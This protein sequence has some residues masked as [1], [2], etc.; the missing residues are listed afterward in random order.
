LWVALI[1]G[2]A[3]LAGVLVA[4]QR[5]W[6][7]HPH[8]MI[9]G[10]LLAASVLAVIPAMGTLDMLNYAAYGRM[11]V[12]GH[13]PYVS[14]PLE[15]RRA[16]DPIGLL[17]TRAW[18]DVPSTY[19]PV[20]TVTEWTASWLGG[21]SMAWTVLWL[22]VW[23]VLAFAFTALVLDRL[24]GPDR[25]ARA[26]AHALWTLNPLLL[27]HLVAGGHVEAL[28]VGLAVAGLWVVR[29][30]TRTG[31]PWWHL[32][33]AGALLGAAAGVKIPFAIFGLGVACAVRHSARA[34]AAVVLGALSVL[35]TG[36][37]L[38]GP[39]AISAL[40]RRSENPS[41]IDPWRL[42]M[43]MTDWT[44][45]P[46]MLSWGSLGLSAIVAV[47]LLQSLPLWPAEQ[48]AVRIA[49]ATGVAWMIVTPVYFP[50]YE[51]MLVPLLAL[52]PASRL[53]EFTMWRMTIASLASLP[54]VALGFHSDG[55]R[56][57]IIVMAGLFTPTVLL[58]SGLVLI[59]VAARRLRIPL[60]GRSP[61]RPET[62]N[63]P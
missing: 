43:V 34:F 11:V 5:G 50:W 63:S 20:A 39:A 18:A 54:G 58:V 17:T 47:L 40:A 33:A 22:K 7:P 48:Q 3:G 6:K 62:N 26:R 25:T 23:N 10:G 24:V 61:L 12:L 8:R 46:W 59:V 57:F 60:S 35:V 30:A 32:F 27:W 52:R 49:L 2:M 41:W 53:D 42:V 21:T 45:A 37:A 55:L 38:V 13:S 56:Q 44:P 19:G 36:Y 14:T 1:S 51:A 29:S 9:V 4:I 16:G 15:L 31:A 28:A